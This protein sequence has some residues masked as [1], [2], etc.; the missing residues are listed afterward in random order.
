MSA[1]KLSAKDDDESQEKKRGAKNK[2]ASERFIVNGL[3]GEKI[4]QR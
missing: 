1:I 4:E 3:S 2:S